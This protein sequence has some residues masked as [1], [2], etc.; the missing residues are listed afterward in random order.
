MSFSKQ[1]PK[2]R[3]KLLYKIIKSL[4]T[5]RWTRRRSRRGRWAPTASSGSGRPEPGL[6]YTL[7]IIIYIYEGNPMKW[8]L[9]RTRY[10]YQTRDGG[11]S[12]SQ[13]TEWRMNIQ[14]DEPIRYKCVSFVLI[15]I[16][17]MCVYHIVR[18]ISTRISSVTLTKLYVD[19]SGSCRHTH[20]KHLRA[21]GK[22][23]I[24]HCMFSQAQWR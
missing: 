16:Q 24:I 14:T 18:N 19:Q 9:W 21:T 22:P 13:W 15:N 8:I 2:K 3:M 23:A 4:T 17:E 6:Q 1:E 7:H 10:E 11:R 12:V 5:S 20:I